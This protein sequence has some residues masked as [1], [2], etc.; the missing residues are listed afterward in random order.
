MKKLS[1]LRLS[2]IACALLGGIIVPTIR[3]N[4]A[5]VFSEN[6]GT[7]STTTAI[8]THDANGGFQNS[9]SYTFTGLGDVR[10]STVSTGYTG[11]SGAANIFLTANATPRTFEISGIVTTGYTNLSLSFG[12]F[13]ST[14]AS[15]MTELAVEYSTDGIT[16]NALTFPAQA[17]GS[18]T[19]SWRLVTITG[20]TIPA[21]ANLRLRWTNTA[22]SGPQFR[23]DDVSLT[24]DLAAGNTSVQ[25][26]T[27]SS[28]VNEGV[29]TVDLTLE[30]T[31]ED[32]VNSTSVDVVL[33]TGAPGRVNSYTT[34]T[35][36]FPAGSSADETL[37]ITVTDNSLCDGNTV[38]GFQLQNI[39]GGA[40]TP[41][42]GTNNEYDLSITDNDVC[43][44]VQ[45]ATT[46]ASVDEDA[47]TTDLTLE[48]TDFSASAA[49][50]VTI[51][52][53]GAT[54]RVTTF[55]TPVTFPANDGSDQ[56]CTVTLDNNSLCDG[57]EDVVFTIT[58]ISGG[59]G[60]PFIGTNDTFT[61]TVQDDETPEDVVATAG[62]SVST[63][64][65]TAN[66]DA[67]PGATGYFLD[68]SPSPTFSTPAALL[69][70]WNFPNNPDDAVADA[71]LPINATSEV[72]TVGANAADFNVAG[73]STNAA[74]ATGWD[75]GSGS[76]Y[77]QVSFSSEGYVGLT[78][79]SAQRSSNTGPRDFQLEYRIGAL[80]TWTSV[81]GGSV[82]VANNFTTGVLNEVDLPAAC[83]DQP[84]VFL[85]WVMTSNTSVNLGT[86]GSGG[87][88]R[89]DD[90]IVN[91]TE[92]PVFV[93]GFDNLSVAGLSQAV[94]GLDPATTYYYR[95][96]STGGCS[97]GENS[98][99]ISVTTDP[100]PVYY[101]RS[102]GNVNDPIWS[103]TPAGTAG[104]AVWN[105]GSSMVVQAGHT[106][107]VNASTNVNDLTT[108]ATSLLVVDD[109]R[110]LSVYGDA[111]SLAAASV[112]DATGEI[113]LLG[114]D[115]VTLT[116]T[117]TVSMNNLTVVAPSGVDVTGDLDIRGA[118]TL[119]DGDFDATS[120]EVRLISDASRT[121]RLGQAGP[122]A[123][124]TGDL[125]VQRYIPGGATNWRLLGSSVAGATVADWD[126]DFFTAGFPGSNF[127]NFIVDGDL[128]PS[129]RLYDETV[130][131][132]DLNAGLIGVSG[133]TEALAIGRGYAAWCGDNLGG[134]APFTVDVKGN[135][136]LAT[137]AVNL[138]VTW[139]ELTVPDPTA[140]GWNLVSNPVAS[141]V[142]FGLLTLGSDM[143]DGYY[144]YDPATGSTA[145]WD[146]SL[147]ES[148]PPGALNGVIQSSQ[149]FWL[150]ANGVNASASIAESAKVSDT[151]G[152]LF[153]GD[154]ALVIPSLRLRITAANGMLDETRVLF[155]DGTPMLDANDAPKM[156]FAHS[157]AP[158]I[159][160]RTADGH[161]LIV[162]RHGTFSTAISIPVTVRVPANG[163]F[164]LRAAI[165]GMDFLSCFTLEDLA[166][167][168]IT[169]LTDGAEYV[170]TMNGSPDIVADR[171][172]LHA[173]AALPFSANDA[174]CGGTS[175]G[176]IAVQV[177]EGPVDLTLAD[178]LGEPLQTA[179]GVAAG[180]FLFADLAAGNYT[181]QVATSA[182]CGTVGAPVS[183]LEPFALEAS[184]DL[185]QA[186]TCPDGTD[187]LVQVSVLGGEAPYTYLWSTGATSE[188]ITGAAG[189]Y[190]LD[191]TDAAGCVLST[192]VAIPAGEGPLAAFESA[193][194]V[195]VNE[196]L[197][198]VNLGQGDVEYTWDL[199]DGTTT[200]EFQPTHTYTLP[201]EYVVTLTA[202]DGICETSTTGTVVVQLT[203]NVDGPA[204]DGLDLRVWNAAEHLVVEHGFDHGRPVFIDVLDATGR[205]HLQ[206]QVGGSPGRVLLPNGTLS[207]GI[208]FVRV[209]S[210]M[211]QRTFRVP[212]VR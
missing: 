17:T 122:G 57:D 184:E 155:A 33:I 97:T 135:P 109:E 9:A 23:V 47:G 21:T 201:G 131:E 5:T 62:T 42:I 169:P 106:V 206:R 99:V 181:V 157:S 92:T 107:T 199:G 179:T 154:N 48:I 108:E 26:A 28:T 105:P 118:L 207:T 185:V 52:A 212:V 53:T 87:T 24:G 104:P 164:T 22:S 12:A 35:V 19:A 209:T 84:L 159:A 91:S 186:T 123:S 102:S 120:A 95:V 139:T 177:P 146:E 152:G 204:V 187:G 136:T 69:V 1:T 126:G 67:V 115:P 51:S 60:T 189:T 170:F 59:Q 191:V 2:V 82:T 176:S 142:D 163:S 94:S 98:N 132:A 140:E 171:F 54:G 119:G 133:V 80:G 116:L 25:F 153:G 74:T 66:W 85:R 198:F 148:T 196:P 70:E 117:G 134:T 11:A 128:W 4:A 10:S 194:E 13:K 161:D 96:R 50:S 61:L 79:S 145:F 27:T 183:I 138:P 34:Q 165:S 6:M 93:A 43:T 83:D 14:T 110:L 166:M 202:F 46:A 178:A 75:D 63:D 68:V 197:T 174:L 29:G 77:W 160:T 101:S 149:G 188:M 40:G 172:V 111:V 38:I 114:L 76:K 180:E 141:P 100:I 65:F 49:T 112:N 182:A 167:G 78:V 16:W 30:I 72:E 103:D 113:E 158:R 36:T 18:G 156:E 192:E 125:T 86:V 71:G 81:A 173:T 73:A 208:W 137:T 8:A 143:L 200:N 211:V 64:S 129:I 41:F 150:K 45:F 190:S 55:T 195:L 175:T 90:I 15:N 203:T 144:V 193:A 44:S 210:G 20:G 3:L 168:T 130:D 151:N 37:T 56:V 147:G 124:Y 39:S 121:G 162:N 58:G 205:L 89:I 7:V 32:A 31:D 88:S 127:P